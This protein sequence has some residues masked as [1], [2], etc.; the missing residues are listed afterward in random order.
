MRIGAPLDITSSNILSCTSMYGC[1]RFVSKHHRKYNN[2]KLTENNTLSQNE[3]FLI[4][5]QISFLSVYSLSI[6]CTLYK[7]TIKRVPAETCTPKKAIKHGI[8]TNISC[9]YTLLYSCFRNT[10]NYGPNINRIARGYPSPKYY[11]SR[12]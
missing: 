2:H 8:I 1:K 9:W 4:L 5:L 11:V 7:N 6:A 3:Y 10:T 12:Y